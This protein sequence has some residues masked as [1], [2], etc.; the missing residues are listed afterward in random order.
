MV[1]VGDHEESKQP[2]RLGIHLELSNPE[3]KDPVSKENFD[4]FTMLNKENIQSGPL[5]W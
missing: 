4:I 3:K 2:R 5:V 1:P